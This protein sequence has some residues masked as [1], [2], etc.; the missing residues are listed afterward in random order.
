[1]SEKREENTMKCP[2]CGKKYS[3]QKNNKRP[4]LTISYVNGWYEVYYCEQGY[5][6]C[7]NTEVVKNEVRKIMDDFEKLLEQERQDD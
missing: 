4:V 6:D 5:R 1:M 3:G 2:L 7:Y